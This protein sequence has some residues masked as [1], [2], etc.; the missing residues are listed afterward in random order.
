[1]QIVK[2][3]SPEISDAERVVS[4]YKRCLLVKV[5]RAIIA[6]ARR[7]PYF[8]AGDVPQ[9]IVAAEHRQGVASNAW[10][11]LKALEIIE[12][13]PM[14]LTLPEQKIFGG[15]MMN[16]NEGAKGRWVC[17]YKLASNARAEAWLRAQGAVE[18]LA[19]ETFVQRDFLATD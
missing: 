17:A 14:S 15:R 7:K 8:C 16:E 11:A 1:M 6:V 9:D 5:M 10:N 19:T 12:Q 13:L 2:T 18:L 3:L 4:H